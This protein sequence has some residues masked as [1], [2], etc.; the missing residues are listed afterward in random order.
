MNDLRIYAPMICSKIPQHVQAIQDKNRA[1]TIDC[2]FDSR[3]GRYEYCIVN[4][5]YQRGKHNVPGLEIEKKKAELLLSCESVMVVDW[6]VELLGFDN[7]LPPGLHCGSWP[8]SD[9]VDGFL[10]YKKGNH[11]NYLIE[12]YLKFYEKNNEY[13]QIFLTTKINDPNILRYPKDLFYHYSFGFGQSV[14][15][16]DFINDETIDRITKRKMY[17]G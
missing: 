15:C 13:W 17:C 2:C 8:K 3:Y 14:R 11:Y 9:N 7:D 10:I 5:P 16:V 1:L 6:D 4:E 12:D